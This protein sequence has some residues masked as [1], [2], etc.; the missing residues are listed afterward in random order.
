MSWLTVWAMGPRYLAGML[1]WRFFHSSLEPPQRRLSRLLCKWLSVA[2]GRRWEFS[3]AGISQQCI[4]T[5]TQSIL[6][7]VIPIQ[8]IKQTIRIIQS[9]T[10]AKCKYIAYTFWQRI[11]F[12]IF[13]LFQD[14][15]NVTQRTHNPIITSPFRENDVDVI[16]VILCLLH[17]L[18]CHAINCNVII[19]RIILAI[20]KRI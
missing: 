3:S 2:F 9:V 5:C 8:Y 11:S 12:Q 15:D 1:L 17:W 4:A 6:N 10:A 16:C 18:L 14:C 7:A 19:P 13:S 20:W